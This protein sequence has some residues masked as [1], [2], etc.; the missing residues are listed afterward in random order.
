MMAVELLGMR[1]GRRTLSD[2]LPSVH[3]PVEAECV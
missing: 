3:R 2:E 1:V